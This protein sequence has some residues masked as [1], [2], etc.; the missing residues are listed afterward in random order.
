MERGWRARSE[1]GARSAWR[2]FWPA[3]AA[4]PPRH[5]S[6]A[7]A[8]ALRAPPSGPSFSAVRGVVPRGAGCRAEAWLWQRQ[9]CLGAPALLYSSAVRAPCMYYLWGL[10]AASIVGGVPRQGW[11]AAL[12]ACS[13]ASAW[14]HLARSACDCALRSSCCSTCVGQLGNFWP[15]TCLSRSFT[16]SS[17]LTLPVPLP[18]R[19]VGVYNFEGRVEDVLV[20]IM[21]VSGN[22][23][24][25]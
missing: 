6:A 3:A 8:T 16:S 2:G 10:V 25:R 1:L 9:V 5:R 20:G 7:A 11:A 22:I 14:E 24:K 18:E 17:V 23:H 19:N 21:R 13:A 12:Q 4:A 15:S